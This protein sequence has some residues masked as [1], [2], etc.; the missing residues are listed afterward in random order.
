MWK[1]GVD[2]AAKC[3]ISLHNKTKWLLFCR[4]IFAKMQQHDAQMMQMHVKRTAMKA[5]TL[6]SLPTEVSKIIR[7]EAKRKGTSINKAVIS[8]LD[9]KQRPE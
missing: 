9:S 2:V 3:Q 7:K 6:R 1:R 4:L 5:V 8:L